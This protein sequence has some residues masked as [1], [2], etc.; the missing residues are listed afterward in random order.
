[1]LRPMRLLS[2]LALFLCLTGAARAVDFGMDQAE[3]MRELGKPVSKLNRNGREVWMYPKNVR[4]EFE[5]G[6]VVEMKGVQLPTENTEKPEVAIPLPVV[7]KKTPAEEAAE[8]AAAE[9]EERM[10]KQMAAEDAKARAALEKSIGDLESMH[11]HAQTPV[12]PPSFD[13][14]A[15]V[16]EMVVKTLLTLAAVILSCK[17]WGAEVSWPGLF[18]VAGA[19]TAVRAVVT[20]I[21]EAAMGMPSLFYADEALAAIAMVILLKRVSYNHALAQAVQITLTTKTFT[22]VVGSFLVTVLMHAL[23]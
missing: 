23:K 22:V 3:V 10:E 9:A 21:G 14:V 11:D 7:E 17:Y 13:Y 6:K 16:I 12:A 5:G 19:D 20:L 1:M 4:I 2:L 8:K 18:L 15:F